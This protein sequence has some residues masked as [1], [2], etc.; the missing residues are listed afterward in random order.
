MKKTQL[1]F[2][3]LFLSSAVPLFAQTGVKFGL[4]AGYSLAMQYGINRPDLQYRVN[5]QS[6]H[7]FSGGLILS[8]PVTDDFHIS[9][10]FLYTQKGSVQNVGIDQPPVETS[11]DY[12]LSYFEIPVVMRYTIVKIKEVGIYLNSGFALSYL[13]EGEYKIDGTIEIGGA[14]SPFGDSGKTDVLDEFDYSFVYGAGCEY[15]LLNKS[16][17]FEYRQTI[18][19]NTLMMPTLDPNDPAPLRNQCYTFSLGMYL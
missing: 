17:F 3:A 5:S 16:W 12:S 14:L 15:Q 11:S 8:F 4:K 9:Q 13:L 1:L 10:E 18:G 19:W 6:K 2:I 7:G